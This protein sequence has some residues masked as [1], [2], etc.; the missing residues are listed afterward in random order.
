MQT[1]GQLASASISIGTTFA[2]DSLKALALGFPV[3]QRLVGAD[4][5]RQ[6]AVDLLHAHP[7]RSGNLHHIGAPFSAFLRARFANTQ[8]AYFADVAALRVGVP[9]SAHR[10][11]CRTTDCRRVSRHRSDSIRN[12]GLRAAP[13]CGFVKA[14][15]PIV[16]IWRANQ[17]DA[18]NDEVID[19]ASEAD[20]VLVLR[21]SEC[22]EF[23]RLP[24][25]QF[26]FFESLD[27]GATLGAA[28][29][30]VQTLDPAFD[31]G[32]ALRLLIDLNLL[33]GL[34]CPS[35]RGAVAREEV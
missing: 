20:H 2:R 5:F 9:G 24:P 4:Y 26:S 28:L 7:S 25:A 14:D 6:L 29:E 18:G 8:Y 34:K 3:I 31:V 13:A 21:T 19:L 32:A 17:L 12:A 27:H 35:I 15:Y 11:R 10:P 33:T 16:R 23:H 22:I 1:D 30:R